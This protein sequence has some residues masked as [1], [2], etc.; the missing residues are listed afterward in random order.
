[1]K[2]IKSFIVLILIFF[3]FGYAKELIKILFTINIFDPSVISFISGFLIFIPLWFIWMK[4]AHFFST[5]E[6]ELTHLLVGLIFL[7]KPDSFM[8]T[9]K[10]GGCVNLYGHNFIITL[11]PYFLPTFSLLLLPV[12]YITNPKFIIYFFVILGILSSYHFFSTVQEFN[13]K[14]TDITKSGRIF[15]TFFIIFTNIFFIGFILAFVIGQFGK[16]WLFIK[17]G[18]VHSFSILELIKTNWF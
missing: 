18:F 14:Q 17:M 16:S 11:A 9:A 15:S 7:K 10:E 6:H 8:V 1:M 13:Y 2:I 4:K 5:F 12:Y 3:I